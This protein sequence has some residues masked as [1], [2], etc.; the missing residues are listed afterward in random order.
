MGKRSNF[1]RIERDFYPTPYKA[2]IPLIPH[3]ADITRYEEP[4]AGNGALIN[5][6]TKHGKVC[7]RASDIEPK[8]AYIK[9]G[10]ATHQYSCLGQAFITNPPWSRDILHKIIVRLSSIA[11]TYLLFDADWMHTKQSAE[12]MHLCKKVISVG[13]VKWIEDSPNTGKDNCAWYQFDK[14]YTG[15][16]VFVGQNGT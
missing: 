3:I 9:T 15:K 5:C 2:V 7:G 11:P 16:T 14:N 4:C 10:D 8:S 6:L 13:R 1:D 12:Y